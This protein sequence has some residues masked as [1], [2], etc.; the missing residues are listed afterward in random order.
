MELIYKRAGLDDLPLLTETRIRVLRAANRLDDVVDMSLVAQQSRD[1]YQQAFQNGSHIA[2]LVFDGA[3]VVGAGGISFYRVMP[4][5]HNP[6][7]W[8]AY[9]MNM[10]TAP[11][12]RRQGIASH[13]LHL[14]VSAAKERGIT[15]ISLEA[16]K[17]GRPL[18]EKYGF[19]SMRDEMELPCDASSDAPH[20]FSEPPVLS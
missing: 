6:T 10:Y 19:T 12:H 16:T 15:Q 17:M 3:Q 5:Y 20:C 13:T 7:G 18:Y 1:Y 11:S 9:V 14:L 8:K 2:Y 4:T